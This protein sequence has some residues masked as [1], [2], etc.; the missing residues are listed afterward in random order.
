MSRWIQVS[1]DPFARTA[2]LRK[3]V[4]PEDGATCAWYGGTRKGG[5]LFV[6]GLDADGV[7]TRIQQS[8]GAFCSKACH[9]AYHGRDR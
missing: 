3:A 1:H 6:Y 7:T 8:S 5:G 9:D 2:L 4:S